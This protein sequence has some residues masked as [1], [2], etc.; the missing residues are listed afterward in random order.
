MTAQSKAGKAQWQARHG[1]YTHELTDQITTRAAGHVEAWAA[2]GHIPL[3]IRAK[4][5]ARGQTLLL[6]AKD[7]RE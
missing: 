3:F 1:D 7:G 4:A 6:P 5:F 2:G